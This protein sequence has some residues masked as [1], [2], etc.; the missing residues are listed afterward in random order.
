MK[1]FAHKY[2]YFSIGLFVSLWLMTGIFAE[3]WDLTKDKR[4]TL[5][6]TTTMMLSSIQE[7]IQIDVFLN[8]PLPPEYQRLR[9]EVQLFI[10]RLENRSPWIQVNYIDPFA[11]EEDPAAV[12]QMMSSYGLTPENIFEQDAT[13]VN[14]QFIFPWVIINR[15]D[16]S[17]RV[18]LTQDQLGLNSV[19]KVQRSIE[20][21]EYLFIDGI[22]Q[23]LGSKTQTIGVVRSHGC[24][25]DI[26]L[27]DLLKSL[28]K[29]YNIAPIDLK[30]TDEL[31]DV[32]GLVN[33]MDLL[34]ISNPKESFSTTE[35]YV[36]DQHL[37]QG[38]RAL[39]LLQTVGIDRD[40]L[41]TQ[42]GQAVA[43][44]RDLNLDPL[45]FKYGI[46]LS[47][48]MVQDIFSAPIVLAQG[49]H[50]SSQF[51][52]FPWPY[53]PLPRP[54]FM[55]EKTAAVWLRF[56]GVLDTLKNQLSKTILLS[57]SPRSRKI[58]TPKLVQ[59]NEVEN[60]I[61]PNRF[62]QGP[63][64][65]GVLVEGTFTSAFTN[66][67]IPESND[68]F[69]PSGKAQLVVIADGHLGEN[70]T[71]KGSPLPLGYDKW[72]RNTYENLS[73]LTNITHYL[74]GQNSRLDMQS[75][76]YQVAYLDAE[77][78]KNSGD[79]WKIVLTL[80]TI[81]WFVLLYWGMNFSRSKGLN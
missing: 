73:F 10:D 6:P 57:S 4:Y 29:Y 2:W 33:K 76:S 58:K 23:L 34:L 78:V 59:L 68:A 52:P 44:K 26:A 8:G 67:I 69:T 11:E 36:L 51:I 71:D 31:Q 75:K 70:Q 48:E 9:R 27:Y 65:I 43:Y 81:V 42:S 61:D 37:M 60:K 19:E 35:Q 74:L 55:G 46:R 24:S 77:K 3:S 5:A 18:K 39:W 38:G 13:G 72:T 14:Q 66:R 45:F 15:A 63:L 17:V 30:K 41:F 28:G 49:D 79:Y 25:P 80:A 21:L 40:S 47:S 62:D 32:K 20:Q 50:N 53:Y 56:P 7:P 1:Q 12:A 54:N 64:P 16:R 22:D